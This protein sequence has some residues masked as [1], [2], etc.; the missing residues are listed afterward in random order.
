VDPD[1]YRGDWDAIWDAVAILTGAYRHA[2]E[3]LEDSG[4]HRITG[5]DAGVGIRRAVPA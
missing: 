5:P 4:Y 2:A 3:S 1:L